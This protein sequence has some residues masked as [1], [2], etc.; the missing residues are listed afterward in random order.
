MKD[1]ATA[2]KLARALMDV[3]IP[4]GDAGKFGED[5]QALETVFGANPGLSRALQNPM[6]KLEDRLSLMDEI[7]RRVKASPAVSKFM[8][9]L[10]ETRNITLIKEIAEAYARLD[11]QR[12]GRL[13]ATIEAPE[14][15]SEEVLGEIRGRLAEITGKDIVLSFSVDPSLIG[16]LVVRLE[17]T[18]I[19]GS[20]RTQLEILKENLRQG[21]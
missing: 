11:D 12:T 2:R 18:V 3:G 6:N 20:I 19:D 9:I 14:T 16:G 7:S 5:I 8:D 13:R 17:N 10:V 21:A 1:T 4:G 15:L